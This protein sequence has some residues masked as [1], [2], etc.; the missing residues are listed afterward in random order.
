[1]QSL[2][3]FLRANRSL[4]GLL[5][6]LALSVKL[7]VPVGFMPTQNDGHIVSGICT[8]TGPA[9]MVVAIPGKS[10]AGEGS[11]DHQGHHEPPC[12]YSGLGIPSLS[13]AAP[14]PLVLALL[15][16]MAAAL[17]PVVLLLAAPPAY[18]RPPLRAPPVLV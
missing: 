2:R 4:A 18:L 3:Q 1:M 13:A 16:V 7:V 9:P 11:G 15:F 17:R 10:D 14:A 12:A 6:V 8:G 5:L